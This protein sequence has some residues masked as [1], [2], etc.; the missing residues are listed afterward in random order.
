MLR[1]VDVGR[2]D[3]R[4][5]REVGV[6]DGLP[7]GHAARVQDRLGTQSKAT[8]SATRVALPNARTPKNAVRS[9]GV[10]VR[11]DQGSPRCFLLHVKK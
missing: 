4:E 6:D 3:S 2:G 5:A 9:K 7:V 8:W 10:G 1:A 11:S